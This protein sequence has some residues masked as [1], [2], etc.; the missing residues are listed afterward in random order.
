MHISGAEC[1]I[2]ARFRLSTVTACL[3]CIFLFVLAQKI[4]KRRMYLFIRIGPENIQTMHVSFYTTARP[5][6]FLL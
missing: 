2:R 4:Y 5:I 3:A 6:A 1:P